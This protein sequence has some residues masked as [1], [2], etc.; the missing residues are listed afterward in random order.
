[1]A[2]SPTESFT[3]AP[4]ARS[5]AGRLR[6]DLRVELSGDERLGQ[7]VLDRCSRTDL[8]LIALHSSRGLVIRHDLRREAIR[9]FVEQGRI[10]RTP[11]GWIALKV[12]LQG[13]AYRGRLTRKGE[14]RCQQAD[15]RIRKL[16][17]ELDT[18]VAGTA[19]RDL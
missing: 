5:E 10:D 12:R 15:A 13:S 14:R 18:T 6:I 2:T 11:Y 8:Y 9:S 16:V 7:L 19:G 1:M 3:L 4:I 17:R